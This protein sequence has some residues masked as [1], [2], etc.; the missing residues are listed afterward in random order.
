MKYYDVHVF[1]SRNSGYSV[2]V[3]IETSEEFL[4][5]DEVIGYTVKNNLFS[6]NGDENFVDRVDE[7]SEEEFMLF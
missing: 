6:E 5:D 1:F 3:S 4:T 7:I 2:G